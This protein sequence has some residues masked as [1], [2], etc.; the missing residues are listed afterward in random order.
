MIPC[1]LEML[2]I[3]FKAVMIPCIVQYSED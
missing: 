2:I 3:Q 1:I